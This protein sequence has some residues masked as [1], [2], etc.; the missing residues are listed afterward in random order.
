MTK[1]NDD[2]MTAIAQIPNLE[3]IDLSANHVTSKALSKLKALTKLSELDLSDCNIEPSSISLFA[4]FS[5]LK[6]ITLSLQ[7]W[8]PSDVGQLEDILGECQL[9]DASQRHS[10]NS[11]FSLLR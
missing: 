8:R 6:K 7:R 2:D 1:C 5:H 9:K 3:K 4:P 10:K 11:T